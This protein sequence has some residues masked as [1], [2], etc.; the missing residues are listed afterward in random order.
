M[1]C[2]ISLQG[3]KSIG[4]NIGFEGSGLGLRSSLSKTLDAKVTNLL[5]SS[6]TFGNFDKVISL[7]LAYLIL[8]VL[9]MS[10]LDTR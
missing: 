4:G 7:G 9:S 8:K 3:N 10:G 2:T 6:I 1:D 5:D